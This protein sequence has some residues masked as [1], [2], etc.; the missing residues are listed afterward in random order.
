MQL[1]LLGKLRLQGAKTLE[2]AG[3]HVRDQQSF[4][5]LWVVDFPLFELDS[6]S[7]RIMAVHHPFTLPRKEDVHYLY[8]DPL[9]VSA[10]NI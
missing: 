5:F 10:S 6:D 1:G 8:T 2:E 7:G 3:I 9:K 4:N